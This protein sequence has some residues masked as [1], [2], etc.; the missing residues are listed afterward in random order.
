[1]SR[2]I[3]FCAGLTVSSLAILILPY[4]DHSGHGTYA[5]ILAV[6]AL[7]ATLIYIA[8][9]ILNVIRDKSISTSLTVT[10][11]MVLAPF[12]QLLFSAILAQNLSLED[13]SG[14]TWMGCGWLSEICSICLL[15][16][17]VVRRIRRP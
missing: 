11:L 15:L 9:A 16:T 12:A 14:V 2:L 8:L 6:L 17:F 7:A 3:A 1:M 4:P 5:S 13:L 10:L